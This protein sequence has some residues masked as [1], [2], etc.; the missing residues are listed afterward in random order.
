M[1][2]EAPGKYIQRTPYLLL[3]LIHPRRP[4]RLPRNGAAQ[5]RGILLL[6]YPLKDKVE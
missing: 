3:L 4:V 1:A 2:A 6:Y 5:L